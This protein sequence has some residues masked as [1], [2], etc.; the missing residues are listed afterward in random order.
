[1]RHIH[2]QGRSVLV[3]IAVVASLLTFG[4]AAAWAESP[5]WL[6]VPKTAGKAVTSGGTGTEAKCET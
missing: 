5:T 3:G 1:M 2:G 4:A 6:C